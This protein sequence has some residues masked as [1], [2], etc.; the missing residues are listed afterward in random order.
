MYRKKIWQNYAED[1]LFKKCSVT[2]DADEKA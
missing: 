2:I 1:K